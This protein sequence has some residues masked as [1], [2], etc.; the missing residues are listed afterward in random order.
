MFESSVEICVV[1]DDSENPEI[2]CEAGALLRPV[3]SD[4]ETELLRLSLALAGEF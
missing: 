1:E 3:A 2:S 4:H